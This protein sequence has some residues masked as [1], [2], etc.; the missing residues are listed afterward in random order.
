MMNV[1]S[2]EL[3]VVIRGREKSHL[4]LGGI[5]HNLWGY[6]E[7]RKRRTVVASSGVQSL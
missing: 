2:T 3:Q 6:W 5:T 1:E 7:V 4:I